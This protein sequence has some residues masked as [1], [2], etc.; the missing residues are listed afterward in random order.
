VIET[1]SGEGDYDAALWI[2]LW[3]R[4]LRDDSLAATR[5]ELDKR[6]RVAIAE[7][8][9][10]GQAAGEFGPADADDV[11]LVLC[12][13]LDGLMVQITLEDPDTRPDRARELCLRLAGR[14]LGCDLLS[15]SMEV[16]Q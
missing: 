8:I 2:E 3:A 16:T 10:D 11:A 4:S 9:R 1:W 12:A 5:A 6:W 15:T 14:E 13:L 7:I